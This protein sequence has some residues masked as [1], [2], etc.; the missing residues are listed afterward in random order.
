MDV[1]GVQC[2]VAALSNVLNLSL[3]ATILH[4]P[5][6]GNLRFRSRL[7]III[8]GDD[9]VGLG[10]PVPE[11]AHLLS[12]SCLAIFILGLWPRSF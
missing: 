10:P 3:E 7:H 11:T 8:H 1:A 5:S 2:L 9:L 12:E 4:G 6:P